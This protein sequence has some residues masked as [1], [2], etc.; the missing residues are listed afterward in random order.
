MDLVTHALAGLAVARAGRF[1][2]GPAAVPVA[3]LG[4]VAPDIDVLAGLAGPAA[5]LDWRRTVTHS[6]I[7]APVLALA[8]A[9]AARFFRPLPWLTAWMAAWAG[10]AS[11]ILLDAAT[12][13]GVAWLWPASA[14]WFG[15]DWTVTGDPWPGLILSLAVIAPFLSALVSGEIGARPSPGV[16]WAVA[17]LLGVCGYFGL[18]AQLHGEAIAAL[19]S[20][21]YGGR[22][23]YRLAALPDAWNPF[24]W[25]GLVDD[26][27]AP[28]RI[29]VNLRAEFDPDA[30]ETFF[31]PENRAA[32]EAVQ[33]GPLYA[34]LRPHVSWP[35]WQVIPFGSGV[36]VR[37]EEL[38]L[39]FAATFELDAQS[40][41]LREERF[42]PPD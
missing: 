40:G 10:I 32:V 33:R 42:E 37:L 1:W 39:G 29:P 8:V 38:R 11:H 7:V 2:T 13:R 27:V 41:A 23:A 30:G 36:E 14:A 21:I 18:R 34:R 15:R 26:R 25:E 5:Y 17:A 6:W 16:G 24:A 9:G 20:R 22:A 3:V 19:N 12:V 28:R 35:R 31:P 4:A